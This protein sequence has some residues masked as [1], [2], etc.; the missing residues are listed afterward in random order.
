MSFNLKLPSIP[1]ISIEKPKINFSKDLK[2]TI[3]SK[4]NDY[5]L[6]DIP[7]LAKETKG[8]IPDASL[9]SMLKESMGTPKLP[10][11][12]DL[13][14]LATVDTFR[15]IKD[16]S[17]TTFNAVKDISKAGKE[18]LGGQKFS[19]ADLTKNIKGGK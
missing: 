1:G 19:I 9:G 18:A 8:I 7:D 17:V 13:K 6:N 4:L 11:I 2:D 12:N 14:N 15:K 3:T 16:D 10:T 5:G